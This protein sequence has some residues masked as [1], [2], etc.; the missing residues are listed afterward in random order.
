M[1]KVWLY[2]EGIPTH[3]GVGHAGVVT[4]VKVSP[5]GRFV[6]STSVDGGIFLWR[7]PHDADVGPSSRGSTASD[8]N[9]RGSGSLREQQTDRSRQLSQ[10]KTMPVRKE[11]INAISIAQSVQKLTDTA[12]GG[13]GNDVPADGGG[14]SVKCLCPR[15]TPCTCGDEDTGSQ[16]SKI[17]SACK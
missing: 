10:K 2:K 1:V 3:V 4:N 13:D 9:S 11:N 7:F 15:G 17:S 6:V 12:A 14:G 16:K 5:D 8:R